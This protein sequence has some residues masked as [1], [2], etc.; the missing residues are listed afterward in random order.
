MLEFM[1]ENGIQQSVIPE[2][3]AEANSGSHGQTLNVT[4]EAFESG[5]FNTIP[6]SI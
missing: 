6:I 4:S 1:R 3:E 5:N 2:D